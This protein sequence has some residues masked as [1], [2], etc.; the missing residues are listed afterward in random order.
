MGLRKMNGC[1]FSD[2]IQE[3]IKYPISQLYSAHRFT[4]PLFL[5][6]G[7]D[8]LQVVCENNDK[9]ADAIDAAGGR[10]HY[11]KLVG[12][13]HA[14]NPEGPL[15]VFYMMSVTFDFIEELLIE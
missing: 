8:D 7:T 2:P 9:M 13:E 10:V 6:Q 14:A 11:L 1:I 12:S 3:S 15:E 4:E 5:K